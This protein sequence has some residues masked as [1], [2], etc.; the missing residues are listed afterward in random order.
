MWAAIVNTMLGIWVIVSPGLLDFGRRAADSNHIAGPVEII[1]AV[2]AIWEINRSA[3]YFNL[4]TGAWL[5]LSP[6]VLSFDS[7]A[8]TWNNL[9]VGIAIIVLSLVRGRI[10]G[11]YGG[12][13]RSLFQ[14]DPV[15]MQQRP[16]NH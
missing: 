16:S 7:P 14:K 5:A 4:V 12:G 9:A 13:W 8:A 10:K 6:F 2:T 11:R 15:H 1:F 3:R